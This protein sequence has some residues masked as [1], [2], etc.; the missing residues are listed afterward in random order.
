MIGGVGVDFFAIAR[1]ERELEKDRR[2]FAEQLFTPDEIDHCDSRR[3]P[4]AHYAVCFA[5]KE[6]L[7]KALGGRPRAASWRDAELRVDA[8]GRYRMALHGD[9]AAA[10]A[11]RSAA[12]V[13]VSVS[14]TA[15]WAAAVVV[16]APGEAC[17][18]EPRAHR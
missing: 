10:A 4:G 13:L 6:A 8:S 3:R 16:L 2:G 18:E 12:D 15:R 11:A 9:I 17:L 14:R 5:A 1:I 7:F